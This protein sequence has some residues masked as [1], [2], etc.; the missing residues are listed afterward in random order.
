MSSR[1]ALLLALLAL[2]AWFILAFVVGVEAGAVHLLL[3]VGV[4]L[5]IRWWATRPELQQR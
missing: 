3:A 5:A 1:S 4:G 2:A